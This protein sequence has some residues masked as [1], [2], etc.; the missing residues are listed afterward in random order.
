MF[1]FSF[2][3]AGPVGSLKVLLS[4]LG[5]TEK[6]SKNFFSTVGLNCKSGVSI[7]GFYTRLSCLTATPE[8]WVLL[9]LSLGLVQPD[10]VFQT[11]RSLYSDIRAARV[12]FP[13]IAVPSDFLD[14]RMCFF[15]LGERNFLIF[16]LRQSEKNKTR[17]EKNSTLEKCRKKA[18]R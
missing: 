6:K 15:L 1:L 12:D 10:R 13:P 18:K 5:S 9:C 4:T 8:I 3:H 14:T 7:H 17:V 11:R 16:G 2:S